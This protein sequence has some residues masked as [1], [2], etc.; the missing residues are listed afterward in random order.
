M[1]MRVFGS[2]SNSNRNSLLRVWDARFRTAERKERR[3]KGKGRGV[4][5]GCSP[6]AK[7]WER[8]A[9]PGKKKGTR[10]KKATGGFFFL[11]FSFV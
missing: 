8:V 5:G 3:G 10:E 7:T 1:Y 6:P 9:P 4:P 2:D 11:F